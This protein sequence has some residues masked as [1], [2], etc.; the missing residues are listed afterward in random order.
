M[1]KILFLTPDFPPH[2]YGGGGVFAMEL[3]S[4]LRKNDYYVDVISTNLNTSKSLIIDKTE[5]GTNFFLSNENI[6]TLK[7]FKLSPALK[8]Y[9]PYNNKSILQLKT[10]LQKEYDLIQHFAFPGHRLLDVVYLDLLNKIKF[11][12]KSFYS[13]GLQGLFQ[14]NIVTK[15]LYKNYFGVN[16]KKIV[17]DCDYLL[18]NSV[19]SQKDLENEFN[20]KKL[21]T[22]IY[23]GIN[24]PTIT[25]NK[26]IITGEYIL[27]VAT[28]TWHKNLEYL[29][30]IFYKLQEKPKFKSYKL[31]IVGKTSQPKVEVSLIQLI[32]NLKLTDKVILTG[33]AT[34]QE[35]ANYMANCQLYIASSIK[36][37]FG[38]TLVEAMSY[39][40]TVFATDAKGHNEVIKDG[41]NG[42]LIPLSSVESATNKIINSKH[43]NDAQ[44]K[45]FYSKFYWENIYK[46]YKQELNI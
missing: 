11:K 3:V 8:L 15:L 30:N 12:K 31:V 32:K 6:I 43:I 33:F 18:C 7:L 28:I 19:S 13:H 36:E 27:Y 24:K 14:K 44:L 20:L 37:G 4:Q 45:M 40:K 22:I 29:V 23:P 21:P 9:L 41:E 46:Q 17:N 39:G 5:Q 38:M 1:K 10:N 25:Q 34:D 26:P 2:F 35:K 16:S 42:Y